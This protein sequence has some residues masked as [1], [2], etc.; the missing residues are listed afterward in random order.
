MDLPELD[1]PAALP[2]AWKAGRDRALLE[3]RALPILRLGVIAAYGAGTF[4]WAL[5]VSTGRVGVTGSVGFLL[6]LAAV[7]FGT[8]AGA[9]WWA[10]RRARAVLAVLR[11]ELGVAPPGWLRYALLPVVV[12]AAVAA[13]TSGRAWATG[14]LLGGLALLGPLIRTDRGR[15]PWA[16]AVITAW[17]LVGAV[18]FSVLPGL[19]GDGGQLL[20]LLWLFAPPWGLTGQLLRNPIARAMERTDR[21][22]AAVRALGPLLPPAQRARGLRLDG[23]TEAALHDLLAQLRLPLE[24]AAL[25]DLLHELAGALESLGDLR[26]VGVAAL[27]VRAAPDDPRAYQRLGAWLRAHD[28]ARA[29]VLAEVAADFEERR[30]TA[31][32]R[33]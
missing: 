11:L 16:L 20:A 12:V 22:G 10:H 14:A 8:L 6:G 5:L 28:P 29:A 3:R 23:R 17:S 7:A 18:G 26:A 19:L 25:A 32:P 24:T 21:V 31:S 1:G 4:A 27:G 33:R 30:L 13:S 15:P 2:A 9:R